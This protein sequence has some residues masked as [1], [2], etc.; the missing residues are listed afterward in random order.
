MD[1]V[2]ILQRHLYS[3][4]R[5]NNISLFLSPLFE[6]D[7][8]YSENG[9]CLFLSKLPNLGHNITHGQVIVL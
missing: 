9:L 3:F 2:T 6:L 8:C 7:L 1:V 5:Y 4:R